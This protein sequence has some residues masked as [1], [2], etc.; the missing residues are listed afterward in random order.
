MAWGELGI[1]YARALVNDDITQLSVGI[2]AKY[3][4]GYEGYFWNSRQESNLVK[5]DDGVKIPNGDLSLDY[6]TNYRYDYENDEPTYKWH[7]NGSGFAMDFAIEY[8]DLNVA[9]PDQPHR[10]KVALAI[11]DIGKITFNKNASTNVY[12][13]QDTVVYL[14]SHFDGARDVQQFVKIGSAVAYDGD[15]NAVNTGNRFSAW[16]PAAVSAQGDFAIGSRYYINGILL[17]P[18]PFKGQGVRRASVIAVTPRI[19]TRHWEVGVPVVLTNFR[20]FHPGIYARIWYFTI[21]TDDIASWFI[22][23]KMSGFDFYF[24]L[25]VQPKNFKERDSKV[26]WRRLAPC[27]K[28]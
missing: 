5:I 17:L 14:N 4:M 11:L 27:P 24:A 1:N 19:E 6:A 7:R 15:S 23:H 8:K 21:G 26:K 2:T 16:M 18:I 25:K 12:D 28:F 3:L 22:P 10:F 20:S 13:K 9:D